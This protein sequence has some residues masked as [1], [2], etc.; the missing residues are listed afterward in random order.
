V[1]EVASVIGVTVPAALLI[2][3]KHRKD[4]VIY[5]HQKP[6]VKWPYAPNNTHTYNA[7]ISYYYLQ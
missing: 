5:C 4:E 6:A 1:Q 3:R 2:R 7:A